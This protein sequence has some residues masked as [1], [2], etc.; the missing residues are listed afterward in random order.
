MRVSG[1]S[2]IT[3]LT[4]SSYRA[5]DALVQG[6]AAPVAGAAADGDAK[7]TT[8]WGSVPPPRSPT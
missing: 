3:G 5:L 8:C 2:G 7:W 6:I 1:N 4:C